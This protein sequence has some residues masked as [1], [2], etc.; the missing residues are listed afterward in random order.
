MADFSTDR[1]ATTGLFGGFA[2]LSVGGTLAALG[3]W[4]NRRLTRRELSRLSDHELE[5]IGLS[6]GDIDRVVNTLR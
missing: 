2:G 5:D 1:P 4:H 6:R 3:T